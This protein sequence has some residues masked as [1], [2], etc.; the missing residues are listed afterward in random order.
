MI[1]T[2]HDISWYI[3]WRQSYVYK[4]KRVQLPVTNERLFAILGEITKY[5]VSL[6]L[7]DTQ[8]VILAWRKA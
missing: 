3:L 4:L 8:W 6:S 1:C 5:R 2:V 7:H